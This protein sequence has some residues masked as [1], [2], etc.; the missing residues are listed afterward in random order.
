MI[1]FTKIKLLPVMRWVCVEITYYCC[2]ESRN[3]QSCWI[4]SKTSVANVHSVTV[5][6][7]GTQCSLISVWNVKQF[8]WNGEVIEWREM[9]AARKH[10]RCIS[11][12]RR[13]AGARHCALVGLSTHIGPPLTTHSN[14]ML[15]EWNTVWGTRAC[16]SSLRYLLTYLL[17]YLL[18]SM[19]STRM[20]VTLFVMY[21][22]CGH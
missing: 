22:D 20:H 17:T 7:Y 9:E 2:M 3:T 5:I 8:V 14:A 10:A 6:Y 13:L 15:F 16:N 4:Q 18:V 19:L 1:W 11:L 21:R 12:F